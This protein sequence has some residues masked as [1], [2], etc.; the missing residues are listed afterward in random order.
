MNGKAVQDLILIDQGQHARVD[1]KS[2]Y[3]FDDIL[4]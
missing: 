1:L 3:Y 4:T 2:E